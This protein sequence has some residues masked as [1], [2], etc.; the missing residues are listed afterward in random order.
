MRYRNIN[1]QFI[2]SPLRLDIN[3]NNN[4]GRFCTF[5]E[6]A[7]HGRNYLVL[8][9]TG[10]FLSIC[11]HLGNGKMSRRVRVVDLHKITNLY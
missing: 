3:R 8:A 10:R 7:E 4:V 11:L 5:L 2:K 9:D 6:Y 1:G